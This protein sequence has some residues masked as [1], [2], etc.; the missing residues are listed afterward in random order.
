MDSFLKD[1]DELSQT[2]EEE[3]QVEDEWASEGEEVGYSKLHKDTGFLEHLTAVESGNTELMAKTNDYLK[4][5]SPGILL[6]FKQTRECF[7]QRFPELESILTTPEDYSKAALALGNGLDLESVEWLPN[8]TKM[9]LSVAASHT[10][11][12][13]LGSEDWDKCKGLCNEVLFL[14]NSKS[15]L[16]E[17]LTA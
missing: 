3:A 7:G 15:K 6:V 12:Q 4:Q 2:S 17:Y 8:K 14:V 16:L 13:K 11:G 5:L 10:A 9:S 1:L